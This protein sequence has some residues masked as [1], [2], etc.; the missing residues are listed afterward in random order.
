MQT[1]Y[2]RMK[3]GTDLIAE[4]GLVMMRK[5]FRPP[6]REHRVTV[7]SCLD[8]SEAEVASVWVCLLKNGGALRALRARTAALTSDACVLYQCECLRRQNSAIP[9]RKTRE[10]GKA[11]CRCVS[12]ETECKS[13]KQMIH[14]FIPA[15]QIC[16][17][18]HVCQPN[19]SAVWHIFSSRPR[20]WF[21]WCGE[22]IITPPRCRTR[23]LHA[24]MNTTM[25]MNWTVPRRCVVVLRR[26]V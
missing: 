12:Y 19:L 17:H 22:Y 11:V 2:K 3:L 26:N 15:A 9:P 6:P 20:H 5:R 4:N 25:N 21:K 14:I 8:N 24:V 18:C 13:V 10:N 1:W 16:L 7:C 23:D